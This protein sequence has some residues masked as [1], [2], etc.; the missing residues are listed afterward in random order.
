MT[1]RQYW[2]IIKITKN[3]EEKEM[4]IEKLIEKYGIDQCSKLTENG[5]VY[6]NK[7]MVR[8]PD[9]AKRDDALEEIK[10]RKQEIIAYFEGKR[11][12]EQRELREREEKINAIDGLKEITDAIEDLNEWQVEFEKS[13]N[14]V[15]GFGVRP[16]PEY[17][18]EGM[19]KKYPAAKAYID[20]KKYTLKENVELSIIG[21]KAL[22]RIIN[23]PED[24]KEIMEDMKKDLNAFAE[25]HLW[26]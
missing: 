14:N 21:K 10:T 9:I 24:H 17:D 16:H 23:S 26:D 2:H 19:Y 4:T 25:K 7:I 8:Y 15:G 22:E 11:E 12:A 1:L 20:A 6:E 18:L 3:K 13:F 5:Y